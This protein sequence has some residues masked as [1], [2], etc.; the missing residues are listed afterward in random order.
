MSFFVPKSTECYRDVN[1]ILWKICKNHG[2]FWNNYV[3]FK[4]HER[5]PQEPASFSHLYFRRKTMLISA[6][7]ID[8]ILRD[9][10]WSF[11]VFFSGQNVDA[12]LV[13]LLSWTKSFCLIIMLT[14]LKSILTGTFDLIL[15]NQMVLFYVQFPVCENMNWTIVGQW[16]SM[17]PYIYGRTIFSLQPEGPPPPPHHNY[18]RREGSYQRRKAKTQ[19]QIGNLLRDIGF[20]ILFPPVFSWWY[21]CV[22]V[23]PCVCVCVSVCVYVYVCVCVCV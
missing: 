22:Y 18:L 4:K 7:V 10:R 15:C 2:N 3:V 12:V 6:S 23:R 19:A 17:C 5:I 8:S 21:V 13:I 20:S 11:D 14:C 9:G 16:T 1:L